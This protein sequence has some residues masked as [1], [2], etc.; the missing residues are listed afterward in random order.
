MILGTKWFKNW[1]QK[2][3]D[4]LTKNCLLNWYSSVIFF[5]LIL[6]IFDIK[7]WLW[8]Y[9]FGTFCRTV[10][11]HQNFVYFLFLFLVNDSWSKIL[12]FWTHHLWNFTTKLILLGITGWSWIQFIFYMKLDT[13]SYPITKVPLN[14]AG[15]DRQMLWMVFRH[16][17]QSLWIHMILLLP[18]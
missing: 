3:K 14:K 8:K 2:K 9:D 11:H 17:C 15:L 12:L 6:L 4:F 7:N 1:H 10:I 5:F 18:R 16:P 13:M